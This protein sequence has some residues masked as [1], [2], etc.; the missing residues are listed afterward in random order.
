MGVG[1]GGVEMEQVLHHHAGKVQAGCVEKVQPWAKGWA[2]VTEWE[3]G[4]SLPA[5][6]A[7][8]A[9]RICQ[10]P[11][12]FQVGGPSSCLLHLP[13]GVMG[14]VVALVSVQ[15]A[16]AVA[17]LAVPPLYPAAVHIV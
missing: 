16:A 10:Q 11:R 1:G 9:E 4:I 14:Q 15:V 2:E 13:P 8:A 7:V 6:I 3:V 5:L 17:T 12:L